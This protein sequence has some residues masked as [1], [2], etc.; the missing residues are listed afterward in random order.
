M[1]NNHTKRRF[2]TKRTKKA[3]SFHFHPSSK[4]Y[5]INKD[6]RIKINKCPKEI[7][8]IKTQLIYALHPFGKSEFF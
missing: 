8:N 4:F 6:C 1:I 2:T 7:K 3:S 5:Q